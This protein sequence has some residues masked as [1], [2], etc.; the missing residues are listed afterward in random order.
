MPDEVKAVVV[1]L[2]EEG[3][4]VQVSKDHK[5]KY[6]IHE[7]TTKRVIVIETKS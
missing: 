5:G 3:K 1:R 4:T 6:H 2:L 7:V